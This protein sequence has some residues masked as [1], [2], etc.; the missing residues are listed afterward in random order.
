[1]NLFV[2]NYQQENN[3]LIDKLEA[4]AEI[5]NSVIYKFSYMHHI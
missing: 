4:I 2:R 3:Y 1:M 5:L